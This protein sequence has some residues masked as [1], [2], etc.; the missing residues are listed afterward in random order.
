MNNQSCEFLSNYPSVNYNNN[1]NNITTVT[2]FIGETT[3]TTTATTAAVTISNNNNNNNNNTS[4][5]NEAKSIQLHNLPPLEIPKS[6]S[7][8]NIPSVCVTR[9]LIWYNQKEVAE[10]LLGAYVHPDWLSPFVHVRPRNG[11][12]IFYRRELATLA[13]K[14]DG[15]LWQRKPSR[16]TTK[17]IHM[18]LK[19]QGIECIIANYAHSALISTFHRRTYALRFNPSIVLFHYLN[20][21]ALTY[22]NKLCLPLQNLSESDRYRMSYIQIVDQLVRMFD[23]F[24]KHIMKPGVDQVLNFDL[25]FSSLIRLLA[26]QIWMAPVYSSNPSLFQSLSSSSSSSSSASSASAAAASA[27]S[28]TAA[29]A[30]TTTT[31]SSSTVLPSHN[32][33]GNISNTVKGAYPQQS[34]INQQDNNN[35]NIFLLITPK[36]NNNSQSQVEFIISRDKSNRRKSPTDYF[37]GYQL[38]DGVSYNDGN[39]GNNNNQNN[40]PY[41]LNCSITTPVGHCQNS[42]FSKHNNNNNNKHNISNDYPNENDVNQII[43]TNNDVTTASNTNDHTEESSYNLLSDVLINWTDNYY[44]YASST[45]CYKDIDDD[46]D[47]VTDDG[48]VGGR[49]Q[50]IEHDVH[51]YNENYHH[52]H[53]SSS[54]N[55]TDSL[56]TCQDIGFSDDLLNFTDLMT[57][58]TTSLSLSLSPPPR[59][60][61]ETTPLPLYLSAYTDED[62]SLLSNELMVSNDT[63][64]TTTTT[65]AA[66]AAAV[67][68]DNEKDVGDVMHGMNDTDDHYYCIPTNYNPVEQLSS[69][70]SSHDS[71]TQEYINE[72]KILSVD[73][74]VHTISNSDRYTVHI[75]HGN[76]NTTNNNDN[77]NTIN[78]SNNANTNRVAG[79]VSMT[80]NNKN[81][82]SSNRWFS[83]MTNDYNCLVNQSFDCDVQIAPNPNEPLRNSVSIDSD[84]RLNISAHCGTDERALS[85]L[86]L[87]G[88]LLRWIVFI[89]FS[90]LAPDIHL[91]IES[92]DEFI[93]LP[94]HKSRIFNKSSFDYETN[95]NNNNSNNNNPMLKY[96][97]LSSP[98]S[99]MPS[100]DVH[101]EEIYDPTL[102]NYL[103][104]NFDDY[105]KL[106]IPIRCDRCMD[107]L[108]LYLT[109]QLTEW[110][111]KMD[112]TN[113][114]NENERNSRTDQ[115]A[116]NYLLEAENQFNG[117]NIQLLQEQ[118]ASL[119]T[120]MSL[121]SCAAALGYSELILGLLQWAVRSYCNQSMSF[122]I[123]N[124]NTTTSTI[125][126]SDVDTE[127][128][129]IL[130]LLHDLTPSN[131]MSLNHPVLTPLASAI[132]YEQIVTTR[133][134]V[135]WDPE[136]LHRP[137]L[138]NSSFMSSSKLDGE[139]TPKDLAL[140]I[141]SELMQNCIEQLEYQYFSNS[142]N[143]KT[144]T[145]V[146]K[147]ERLLNYA[148]TLASPSS[149][150]A[151]A[152]PPAPPPPTSSST[153]S[154]LLWLSSGLQHFDDP[155]DL[156]EIDLMSNAIP[157]LDNE[158]TGISGGNN[159]HFS[160]V[161]GTVGVNL[162]E[163]SSYHQSSA[164]NRMS[165]I[166]C[167]PKEYDTLLDE[168]YPN[169]T[170]TSSK[171]TTTTTTANQLPPENLENIEPTDDDNNSNNNNN[172]Y[173]TVHNETCQE[174]VFSGNMIDEQLYRGNIYAW[175]KHSQQQQHH[176]YH[177]AP[178]QHHHHRHHYHYHRRFDS[179]PLYASVTNLMKD[180]HSQMFCLADRII[181]AMPRRIV[182][183][184]NQ[185]CD[186]LSTCGSDNNNDNDDDDDHDD[187]AVGDAGDVVVDE[188]DFCSS[189]I[190]FSDS[191]LGESI[192]LSRAPVDQHISHSSIFRYEPSSSSSAAATTTDNY[193]TN[194]GKLTN[195]TTT[196]ATTRQYPVKILSNIPS[197]SISH[198]HYHYHPK[199]KSI[200]SS[201]NSLPSKRPYPDDNNSNKCLTT[202][203]DHFR[204]RY[205]H[206]NTA[207]TGTTTNKAN[208]RL[209][210]A[211]LSFHEPLNRRRFHLSAVQQFKSKYKPLYNN[212]N[213][214]NND[215]DNFDTDDVISFES[216]SHEPEII[217]SNSIFNTTPLSSNSFI[218]SE[219]LTGCGCGGGDGG[220]SSYESDYDYW[221]NCQGRSLSA[222]S[223]M[224]S[225]S[226]PPSTA[227]IA[228]HFNA[229]PDQFMENDLSRLTLSDQEQKR[230][231]EAAKIIQKYY[232]A[233]KKHNQSMVHGNNSNNNSNNCNNSSNNQS[234]SNCPAND[235][236]ST[237]VCDIQCCNQVVEQIATNTGGVVVS[238]TPTATTAVAVD[239]SMKHEWSVADDD[240]AL[241]SFENDTSVGLE[242]EIE[243][244][245]DNT[246]IGNN[247][248]KP[249]QPSSSSSLIDG[250]DFNCCLQATSNNFTKSIPI[251]TMNSSTSSQP[252]PPPPPPP[253]PPPSSS[254]G[255]TCSKEIEAAII[256]QSYY[257][258][259][260]QYAYYKRLCQAALLIQNQ[261][262]WYINHKKNNGN[263]TASSSSSTAAAA[264]ASGKLRKP[265]PSQCNNPRY[266]TMCTRKPKVTT[267][268][269]VNIGV[270]LRKPL[271][272]VP[273]SVRHRSAAAWLSPFNK[274]SYHHLSP[275]VTGGGG[276][277]T[278]GSHSMTPS[279]FICFEEHLIESYDNKQ[280]ILFE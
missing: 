262:R 33:Y 171:L 141:H 239:S 138:Y 66:P 52:H 133:F 232:R 250:S 263:V 260:K 148:E 194:V 204:Y 28:S 183:L 132:L 121:L 170:D 44:Q 177:H 17:E 149:S 212:S 34:D 55:E 222:F 124:D 256:I 145:P 131:S 109:L 225:S 182:N 116:V 47:I 178:P 4:N 83:P 65:V 112:Y 271:L 188:E 67:G 184:H 128:C 49:Q 84:Q 32:L 134:L 169:L 50:D 226:P 7:H 97:S 191:A 29:A 140:A 180:D 127:L 158:A 51:P 273:G 228:E 221:Y 146:I 247:N 253:L 35:N 107:K 95:S 161:D 193:T 111:K 157:L 214:N 187:G 114:F 209:K 167:Q 20:V 219:L 68:N 70:D 40:I 224:N 8:L 142:Q 267:N 144:D 154:S 16:R 130:S 14:Q 9:K 220:I 251:S 268:T 15:Y 244:S 229:V 25:S 155:I 87:S 198:H 269:D 143:Y 102:T 57:T 39:N 108:E 78:T 265:R 82:W 166:D 24:P 76:A 174:S 120:D 252:Q 45:S 119:K 93:L 195:T 270:R 73:F 233:Y 207:T 113:Q 216:T 106:N 86:K 242:V 275:L 105:P 43:L 168:Y 172:L 135:V 215:N 257:R 118:V 79:A 278:M 13:R 110:I 259:Y 213:N 153:S 279:R 255:G 21:P 217:T 59:P 243:T 96:I 99:S 200:G 19:V 126:K 254:T 274:P 202:P 277:G 236:Y 48:D 54:S 245:Y 2:P 88:D 159:S 173:N 60:S 64:T 205:S 5:N 266:R 129:R 147:L 227:Q 81:V 11:S 27:S 80:Q 38:S 115:T 46:D 272:T 94:N 181:E 56:I 100:E 101:S 208:H 71:Y 179:A 53:Q 234:M 199:N 246:S 139:F 30:T 58:T 185:D 189:S 92:E 104:S 26:D 160:T 197:K 125:P 241:L 42:E 162:P 103:T 37:C 85:K 22:D 75:D 136:A 261:Y 211:L 280:Q 10:L 61:R 164:V 192:V 36:L 77:G 163:S 218:S 72:D 122:F 264:T 190:Q 156:S 258:R 151:P 63:A 210:S 23:N 203:Y 18:V 89:R 3:T 137:C 165:S 223:L 6:L 206:N 62:L 249:Q 235:P 123:D 276:G 74:N 248:N 201:F 237:S 41:T 98:S 91:S 1:N 175:R 31:A 238:P 176:H 240:D 150:P 69:F 196:A 12:V 90:S 230:L 231:Y 117:S 186:N 152:P